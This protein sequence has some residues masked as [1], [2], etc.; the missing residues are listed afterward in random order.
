MV[1]LRV[2]P[3]MILYAIGDFLSTTGT[4]NDV[5]DKSFIDLM[6]LPTIDT[7]S[8]ARIL[9]VYIRISL[10]LIDVMFSYFDFG[11]NWMISSVAF[12]NSS[13]QQL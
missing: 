11:R 2:V 8:S 7:S 5:D 13:F 4:Q 9:P 3:R 1:G 6:K 12:L 10:F